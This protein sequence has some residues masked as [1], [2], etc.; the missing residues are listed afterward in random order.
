MI[1]KTFA[2][3]CR[4]N[5]IT[6]YWIALLCTSF[7]GLLMGISQYESYE[8]EFKAQGVTYLAVWGQSALL[9]TTLFFPILL[10]A[11][12]AQKMSNEHNGRNIARLK[13]IG[14][15][16][17]YITTLTLHSFVI[18][19]F[20]VLL[21]GT[22]QL[23]AGIFLHFHISDVFSLVPRLFAIALA[24]TAWQLIVVGIG[25]CL[26]GFS[27]IVTVVL[28]SSLIGF[29]M[30]IVAPALSVVYPPALLA[31]ASA[32]RCIGDFYAVGS[33]VISV[34]MNLMWII[35]G[36]I[37]IKVQFKRARL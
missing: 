23:V 28:V 5:N 9:P 10:G 36:M 30:A 13:A 29:G 21:F 7:L 20:S 34:M 33:I 4:K 24:M 31:Y 15:V 2:W 3:E 18:S 32:V 27:S 6:W 8:A 25:V 16:N 12:Q 17:K 19:M 1:K 37:F 22:L 35:L 11:L 14:V 26:S